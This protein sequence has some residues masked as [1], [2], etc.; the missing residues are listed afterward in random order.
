MWSA[1]LSDHWDA[2]IKGS[3]A[4][5][6]GLMRAILDE[7][8]MEIGASAM[9]LL[10][11]IEKIYDTV[12]LVILMQIAC[13]SGFPTIA[14]GLEMVM[15]L[16]PRYL[17]EQSAISEAIWPTKSLVAG[18][19]RGATLANVVLHPVLELAHR[20]NPSTGL[21]TF[22]DDTVAN[23]EG[24]VNTVCEQLVEV[25]TDIC[26][27]LVRQRMTISDKTTVIGSDLEQ[28]KKAAQRL[29]RR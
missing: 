12:S 29:R 25:S 2:A 7:T 8:G 13:T 14:V 27:G 11:D 10:L 24:S 28:V 17:Q 15:F 16:G 23:C 19:A 18:S 1:G 26:M 5:R 9:T 4:L 22:V 3:S 6:A 21:W 20:R